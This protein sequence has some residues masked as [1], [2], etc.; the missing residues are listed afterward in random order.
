MKGMV[1]YKLRPLPSAQAKPNGKTRSSPKNTLI[2]TLVKESPLAHS[3]SQNT[4]KIFDA[5]VLIQQLPTSLETFGNI[6]DFFL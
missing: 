5:M 2:Y 3:L 6:S 4:I 1:Q